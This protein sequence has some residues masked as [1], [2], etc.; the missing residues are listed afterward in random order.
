MV[1]KAKR[2]IVFQ[3]FSGHKI[4]SPGKYG[5]GMDHMDGVSFIL[6]SPGTLSARNR[7]EGWLPIETCWSLASRFRGIWGEDKKMLEK[8]HESGLTWFKD[9]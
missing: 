7:N 1:K 9:V 3:V 8:D 2:F 5:L 6:D 4:Q